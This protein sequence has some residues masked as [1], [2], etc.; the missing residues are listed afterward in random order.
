MFDLKPS[1]NIETVNS[2]NLVSAVNLVNPWMLS[3][4]GRLLRMLLAVHY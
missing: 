1:E 2:I 4:L 3:L